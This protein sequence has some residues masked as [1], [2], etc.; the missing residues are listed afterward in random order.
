MPFV[1]KMA[2]RG[3]SFT[4]R[5]VP[6]NLKEK[7]AM[8][9]VM[10]NPLDGT[11]IMSN[12]KDPRWLSSDGWVKMQQTFQFYDGSR[13]TIHYVINKSLKLMDDFKFVFPR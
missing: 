7:L 4:G 10:S 5:R 13:T 12:L 9:Q 3:Q 8:E 2:N 6:Y 1:F 11:Q